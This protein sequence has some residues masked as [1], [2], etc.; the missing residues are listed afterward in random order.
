MHY[1]FWGLLDSCL[2]ASEVC[3]LKIFVLFMVFVDE[4]LI[5]ERLNIF[6]PVQPGTFYR[7]ITINYIS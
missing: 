5:I 3:Y 6:L 4:M 1:R 7:R 2:A